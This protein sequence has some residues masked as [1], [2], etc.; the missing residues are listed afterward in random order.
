MI[1]IWNCV[2]PEVN[3]GDSVYGLS[4]FGVVLASEKSRFLRS[5]VARENGLKFRFFILLDGLP[6][7]FGEISLSCSGKKIWI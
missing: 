7:I 1:N 6:T 5:V 2:D 3:I 4:T